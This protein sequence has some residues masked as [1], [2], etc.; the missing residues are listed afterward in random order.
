MRSARPLSGRLY[1][2]LKPARPGGSS[3]SPS[4]PPRSGLLRVLLLL[5][6]SMLLLCV[7]LLHPHQL[8]LLLLRHHHHPLLLL[9]M[10]L[11]LS[12]HQLSRSEVRVV[13]LRLWRRVAAG[14]N[15]GDRG[16]LLLLLSAA[17]VGR[18]QSKTAAVWL[19]RRAKPQR[20]VW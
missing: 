12:A 17:A 14:G 2:A 13:L 3:R 6:L 15:R 18:D 20:A 9:A 19:G 8:L 7:L 16:V 5:L 11:L 4:Y 10:S 1:S